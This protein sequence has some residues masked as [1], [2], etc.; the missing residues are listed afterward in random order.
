MTGRSYIKYI[1]LEELSIDNFIS[2]QKSLYNLPY[3][4]NDY[5]FIN[6]IY[7]DEGISELQFYHFEYNL[8]L[9]NLEDFFTTN[10]K[11]YNKFIKEELK[12]TEV[13]NE[14]RR[15]EEEED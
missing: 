7:K 6:T 8:L 1:D 12:M 14:Q 13:N 4:Q 5:E 11:S 9:K 2:Y 15:K 10:K 3:L